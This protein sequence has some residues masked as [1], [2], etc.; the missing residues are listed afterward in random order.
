[1]RTSKPPAIESAPRCC[2]WLT[3]AD[4]RVLTATTLTDA[5]IRLTFNKFHITGAV[6]KLSRRGNAERIDFLHSQAAATLLGAGDG[7]P[8]SFPITV[9]RTSAW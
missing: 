6:G 4:S 1:M 2:A 8:S 5:D 3:S 9:P 7:A